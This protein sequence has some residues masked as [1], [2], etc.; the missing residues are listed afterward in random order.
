MHLNYG[1]SQF[2]MHSSGSL[3][4]PSKEVLLIADVHFGKIDHFRKNGSALPNEVSLENFKKLDRVID[5]FQ[6]KGII[7]LG[8]L[9]HSTQNRDWDRF[10][11]WVKEQSIKMTLVVGNHDIIPS[12]YFEDLGIEVVPSLNIDT[13][14]LSHHPEEKQGFW[15]ICGHLHPGYRLRGQGKQQLKLSCFYKKKYQLILPA[16][17]A[18][19]G[20]FLIEPEDNEDVFILAENE[21]LSLR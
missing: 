16:F 20:H 21:V 5:E 10:T 13:L 18:F 1:N 9:F 6:P 2:I 14:F 17:G 19:T 11:A 12:Y 4:W 8:D 3:Y 7:F 15:N